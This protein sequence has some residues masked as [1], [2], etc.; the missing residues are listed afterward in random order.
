MALHTVR[1]APPTSRET[2]ARAAAEARPKLTTRVLGKPLTFSP[3]LSAPHRSEASSSQAHQTAADFIARAERFLSVCKSAHIKHAPEKGRPLTIPPDTLNHPHSSQLTAKRIHSHPS[4]VASL[5]KAL[6]EKAV[7]EG[8]PARAIKPL[9]EAVLRVQPTQQHLTPQHADFLQWRANPAH[10]SGFAPGVPAQQGVCDG[11]RPAIG[12]FAAQASQLG[13]NDC[14]LS[15]SLSSLLAQLPPSPLLQRSAADPRCSRDGGA[16]FKTL[17]NPSPLLVV[18][19]A[20]FHRCPAQH[21]SHPGCPTRAP[22]RQVDAKATH[23]V[24]RDFVLYCY[25]G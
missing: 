22:T 1:A 8:C 6:K 9:R 17:H 11:R 15:H 10:P 19:F 2:P 20:S 5:C 13:S 21:I 4:A 23:L 25:Y 24:A 7:K 18:R 12:G 16:R 14:L 3:L